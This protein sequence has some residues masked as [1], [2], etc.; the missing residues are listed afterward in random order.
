ME[1]IEKILNEIEKGVMF[2]S[3]FVIE[4]MR[5]DYSDEYINF[6]AQSAGNGEPTLNAHQ[7]IGQAIKQFENLVQKQETP[8]LSFNIHGN[9]SKCAL[10]L[11]IA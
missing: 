8:S 7:R 1:C 4:R 10:W 6:V 2:D 11:K 5:Q 3:H 9:I